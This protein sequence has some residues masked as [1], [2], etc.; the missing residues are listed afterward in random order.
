[1]GKK[2]NIDEYI[3]KVYGKLTI[4]KED[5]PYFDKYGYVKKRMVICQCDCGNITTKRLDK[6]RIG[7]TL[8]CGCS[9][10]SHGHSV[11][12][13][14]TPTYRSWIAMMGRCVWNS[15]SEYKDNGIT[16]CERWYTYTNFLEDMGE[17]PEGTSIDRIDPYGNYEPSNCRWATTKVQRLNQRDTLLVC[18]I[19]GYEI[20][21][22]Y[23]FNMEQH[24]KFKH[25]NNEK[26]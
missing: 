5:T 22:G 11:R 20:K 18:P 15:K 7:R 3:G 25:T 17:R 21:N 23:K 14:K 9:K 26:E 8:S 13:K 19:C 10:A 12:G 1:M 6:M 24:I 16:I 4:M 2:F